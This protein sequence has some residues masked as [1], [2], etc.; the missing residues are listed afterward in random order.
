METIRQKTE[1]MP[2]RME[3]VKVDVVQEFD[4]EEFIE[5]MIRHGLPVPPKEEIISIPNAEIVFTKC[6][7]W[8]LSRIHK[9]YQPQPEYKEVVNW[10][11]NNNSKGLLLYGN[12]GR[13]KSFIARYVIPAILLKYRQKAFTI[14]NATDMNEM[15]NELKYKKYLVIDDLGC[16]F[17]A[18]IYGNKRNAFDEIIDAAEQRG[19]LLVITSNLTIDE[20]MQRYGE[21][22]LGRLKALTTRISFTGDSLR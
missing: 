6:Y 10:L 18:N 1:M 15:I 19:N 3:K 2:H 20:L 13:G 9:Q 16:E 22:V 5:K 21:R 8:F 11:E 12:C 4:S 14:V 17:T 7:K